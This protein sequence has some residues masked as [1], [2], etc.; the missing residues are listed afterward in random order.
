MSFDL[1][2][3]RKSADQ[4]WDDALDTAEDE[5]D[6]APDAQAWGRIVDGAREILGEIDLHQGGDYLELDHEPTGIQLSLYA[7]EAA[8]TVPYWYSGAEAQEI[9][10]TLYRL[11]A[12]IE[13]HTEFSGYDPQV[14]LPVAEVAERPEL[15]IA[16]F[17][18]VAQS[19]GPSLGHGSPTT[20]YH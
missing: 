18:M 13:E 7:N 10:R 15:A 19:L 12:V 5:T 9:V 4:S 3:V 11:A 16:S 14:D 17:D 2:F 1:N 8:I 20:D 6:G